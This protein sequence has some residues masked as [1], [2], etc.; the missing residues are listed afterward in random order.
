MSI[1]QHIKPNKSVKKLELLHILCKFSQDIV[2][3]L[4]NIFENTY[5]CIR[6]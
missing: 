2:L 6:I 1:K 5:T 3:I 4:T